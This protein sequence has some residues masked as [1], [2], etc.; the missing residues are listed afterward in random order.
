M[1]K[2]REF[3]CGFTLRTGTLIISW[4][5]LVYNC[6]LLPATAQLYFYVFRLSRKDFM[7]EYGGYRF[8]VA[9]PPSPYIFAFNILAIVVGIGVSILAIWALQK[10]EAKFLNGLFWYLCC[11]VIFTAF[12]E[13]LNFIDPLLEESFNGANPITYI[14]QFHR[15]DTEYIA[16]LSLAYLFQMG[17][18]SYFALVVK[19][20]RD[21]ALMNDTRNVKFV[22][23]DAT[24]VGYIAA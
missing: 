17:I 23:P 16:F 19:S 9:E 1:V 24:S 15:E 11:S 22:G 3:C 7:I 6:I 5:L 10:N 14:I 8:D 18:L 20:C 2:V 13:V 21:Y 4:S 12:S